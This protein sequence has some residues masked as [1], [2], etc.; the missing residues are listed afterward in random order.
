MQ[1]EQRENDWRL[2]AMTELKKQNE[3]PRGIAMRSSQLV[4][5]QV[6][7]VPS[8]SIFG[9][10]PEIFAIRSGQPRNDYCGFLVGN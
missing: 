8:A 3:I 1:A 9:E 4:E 7:Y 5:T 2:A 10:F 6:E